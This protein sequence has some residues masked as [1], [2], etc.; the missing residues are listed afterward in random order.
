[1]EKASR[2]HALRLTGPG[3][4]PGCYPRGA[5]RQDMLYTFYQYKDIYVVWERGQYRIRDGLAEQMEADGL[6]TKESR[7]QYEQRVHAFVSQPAQ[8]DSWPVEQIYGTIHEIRRQ[9]FGAQALEEERDRKADRG[10]TGAEDGREKE[11]EGE[12]QS[13]PEDRPGGIDQRRKKQELFEGAQTVLFVLCEPEW[14]LEMQ[15]DVRAACLGGKDVFVLCAPCPGKIL[16]PRAWLE[17]RLC[18]VLSENGREEQRIAAGSGRIRFLLDEDAGLGLNLEG[19]EADETL[20]SGIDEGRAAVLVYGEDGFWHCRRLLA[21]A[22][23]HGTPS[24]YFTRAMTNQM[25]E[26]S[27]CIVYVPGNFDITEYV[28]LTKKTEV[29]YWQ[30]ARLWEKFGSGIYAKS[31]EELYRE[32]P[33]YFLNIYESGDCCPEAEEGY[34]I[35]LTPE[36][37]RKDPAPTARTDGGTRPDDR[38]GAFYRLREE[39]VSRYL[40]SRDGFSY[41]SVYLDREEAAG[42]R[43]IPWRCRKQQSGVWVQGVRADRTRKVRVVRWN[44]E[45]ALRQQLQRKNHSLQIF[46]NFLFFMTPGLANLY[47]ELRRDRPLEQIAFCRE[48]LDYMRYQE[49]GKRRETFPLYRKACIAVKEN[50]EFL[51]FRFRL[52]GGQV[53]AGGCTFR[54]G[55]QDVDAERSAAPVQ[56]FTP[57]RS[58]A[59]E[60]REAAQYRMTVGA[61]R[62]NLVL[63]QDRIACI[64]DGEVMMPGIGV[65]LSLD[66]PTGETFL[67][68]TALEGL[69]QGYYD[70]KNLEVQIVLDRPEGVEEKQWQ[71]VRWAYGGG[72]M[73]IDGGQSIFEKGDGISELEK[74]GWLSPL[75]CQTQETGIHKPARHPRTA[76]GLTE[77]GD[78]FVLVFSG[79]TLLSAGAD[80]REM[81]EAAFRLYP[82]VRYLMNVDG[83]GSSVLGMAVNGSFMELSYPATSMYSC[84]GMVRPVCSLLCLE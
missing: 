37:D 2:N 69:G 64:R 67:R 49:E 83:G 9:I 53:K 61:G 10:R 33:Q 1:M 22:V 55:G 75:S 59:E 24:G 28:T 16:P 11:P 35:R 76:V 46:S 31:V 73:L 32:Y 44:G 63:I 80:Y 18:R 50:G 47:N 3:R 74:E 41:T 7:R 17:N 14:F 54:F 19:I 23:V 15:R 45:E 51:F 71:Q 79:R 72:M 4:L 70:A 6:I 52:G 20:Q 62:I 60:G 36:A 25:D 84:A 78:F 65:V 42:E 39:A 30:L 26:D 48:H 43:E 57:Y 81:C 29:S 27:P 38:I 58:R 13:G 56:I 8:Y 82:D 5:Y 68:T 12:R 40:N 66:R 77:N 34:P 21:D